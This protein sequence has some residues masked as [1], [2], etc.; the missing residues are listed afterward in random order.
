[1]K[2]AIM[3]PYL[4]PYIGYFQLINAVDRFGIGDD[5][6]FIKEGWINR[7]RI[8][9]NQRDEYIILP[10]KKAPS[11]LRGSN[12]AFKHDITIG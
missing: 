5:V 8:G 7:N 4:F 11:N 3:Q 1:M 9:I 2:V 10:V 6:Q 12:G